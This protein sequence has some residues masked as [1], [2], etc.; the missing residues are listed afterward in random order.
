MIDH[1]I[2][3]ICYTGTRLKK[4]PVCEDCFLDSDRQIPLPFFVL[5]PDKFTE[6]TAGTQFGGWS[7]EK[8]PH[9]TNQYG[10]G[11]WSHP[12][13]VSRA[14]AAMHKVHKMTAARMNDLADRE[15]LTYLNGIGEKK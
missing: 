2:C 1:M 8:H 5:W 7:Q 15:V 11:T 12:E 13:N 14:F 6:L 9:P 3:A 10:W 4:W